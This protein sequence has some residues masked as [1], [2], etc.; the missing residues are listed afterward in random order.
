MEDFSALPRKQKIV[1]FRK[2]SE[3]MQCRKDG[4][5]VEQCMR[6]ADKAGK[7]GV[8]EKQ[9]EAPVLFHTITRR[10]MEMWDEVVQ[11]MGNVGGGLYCARVRVKDAK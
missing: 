2:R 10:E 1:E 4:Q 11:G 5:I 9:V 3:A 7:L 8:M 6:V